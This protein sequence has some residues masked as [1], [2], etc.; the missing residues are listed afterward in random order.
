MRQASRSR[1]RRV[2]A[3]AVAM[4]AAAAI[5]RFALGQQHAIINNGQSPHSRLRSVDLSD[6][7]WT[8]GVW[9]QKFDLVKDVTIPKMWEYFNTDYADEGGHHWI[10]FRITAG[11]QEGPWKGRS[12]HDG[13]FYK[14]LESVAHVYMVT[15]DPQLDQQMDEVIE[16]IGKAQQPDGYLSTQIILQKWPRFQDIHHHELYNMGHLMTAAC[17]HHRATGKDSFLK[18]ARKVGDYLYDTFGDRKPELAHFGFNPSN[19]MGAVELY[20]TTGDRKYLDLANTFIDM[21]GSQPAGS[22]HTGLGGTDQTQ[23]R[24]PLRDETEAV[25][26]AVTATYL[27]CGAADAYMESGDEAL[28]AALNRIWSDVVRR[29]LYIHGGVGPLT[30][31]MSSRYDDVHEA[32][33]DPYFLPNRQC[34]CETCANIGN[35]M[36]NWRMLN[37]TGDARYADVMERVW[38]NGGISG[39]GLDGDAFLYTNVLRRFGRDVPLLRSD[40]PDRWKHRVGYCCPPQLARTVAQMHGYVYSTSDDGLWI[41]LYGGNALDTQLADARKLKL[42][43]KTNYPWDGEIRLQIEE[44]AAGKPFAI[45]LRI[46]EWA[47][48]ATVRVNGQPAGVE[49]VAGRYATLRRAWSGGDV[50]E[51]SLPMQVRLVRANPLAEELRGQVAVMRG[52]V[53]YCLESVDLPDRT[54]VMEVVLPADADLT[55][56]FDADFLGGVVVLEG[57]A[58]HWENTGWREAAWDAE[59]L[60]EDA[61]RPRLRPVSVRLIPY[62]ASLNRGPSQMTVW[63]LFALRDS[64]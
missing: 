38:Y 44:V 32:F 47:I 6:V 64:S 29:K 14:W 12:W 52:P 42:T 45:M 55:P 34:Y 31:G 60:Y 25:G 15:K 16:I 35:A 13:D 48:G 27:Y 56:R 22:R 58:I 41:H 21:R 11:L 26:H 63:M 49:V 36:W 53:L 39:L 3:A 51:L 33:A 43:Q 5:C 37:I 28:M 59:R 62:H 2:L 20:R 50:V 61:S 46:P 30:R 24:V 40:R 1:L 10:N 7:H 19:I 57:R 17:I 9:K 54:D 18:I 8:D 23:D 4:L